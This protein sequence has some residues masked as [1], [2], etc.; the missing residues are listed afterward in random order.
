MFVYV[1]GQSSFISR[2]LVAPFYDYISLHTIITFGRF[3]IAHLY[4]VR[5]KVLAVILELR[6]VGGNDNH[7]SEVTPQASPERLS[8][9]A[10]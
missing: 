2:E 5:M 4:S 3:F 9:S 6:E 10:Y 1:T 7:S 8:T